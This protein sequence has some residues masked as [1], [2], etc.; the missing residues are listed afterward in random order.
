MN[1]RSLGW[2]TGGHFCTDLNQG[3]LP[4]LLPFLMADHHLTYAAAAGL[5]FANSLTSS[6]IQPLFGYY[7]DRLE[8]PVLL[9]WSVLL[10]GAGVALV[11]W[12]ESYAAIFC[13]VALSGVGIAAF[14]PEA[15]RLANLVAGEKKATG[16][17]IFGIGGNAGFAAGPLLATVLIL[18]AGLKA[19]VV[20]LLPAVA[21][22]F[23]LLRRMQG[24]G[25]IAAKATA[26][27]PPPGEDNWSAFSRLSLVVICRSVLFAG[28]N[29][30][31]PLYWLHVLLQSHTAGSSALTL[32]F[33]VGVVGTFFGGRWADRYGY[34]RV[35]RYGYLLLLPVLG[36]FVTTD[37]PVLAMAL[38]VP[39]GLGLFAPYSPTVVLGQKYLPRRMGFAAGITMGLAVS[40]GGV[41]APL[42]GWLADQH[43]LSFSFLLLTALP[44]VAVLAACSLPQPGRGR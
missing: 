36:L 15:A 8:R 31:I 4:A 7:A 1:R 2:L 41:A 28:L 42:L 30:F 33:T 12:L 5:M 14:H 26:A 18:A 32:L 29:T 25:R 34:L 21:I 24:F 17:G 44:L 20:F 19:T 23:F 6:I 11:G 9:P 27:A 13:A 40:V 38:L 22:W 43:G 16:L 37:S 10:A 3:A 35:I 39:I